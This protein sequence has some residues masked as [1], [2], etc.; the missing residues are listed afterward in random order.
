[1]HKAISIYHICNYIM[2]TA[3][4]LTHL[5][6]ADFKIKVKQIVHYTVHFDQWNPLI[7]KMWLLKIFPQLFLYS[8]QHAFWN[9]IENKNDENYIM[10]S[11]KK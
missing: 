7:S 10:K 2:N 6:W 4:V 11:D 8:D 3:T 9:F 5:A 1:M